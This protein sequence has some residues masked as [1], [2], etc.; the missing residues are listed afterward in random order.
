M[1]SCG[2]IGFFTFAFMFAPVTLAAGQYTQQFN[3]ATVTPTPATN[4]NTPML[5]LSQ[6][7]NDNQPIGHPG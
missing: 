4:T 1:L 6:P 7:G 2:L 3:R 5:I